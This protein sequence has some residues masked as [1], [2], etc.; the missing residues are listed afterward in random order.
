MK[1]VYLVC[2]ALFAAL[3]ITVIMRN[4]VSKAD[5]LFL[6]DNVEALTGFEG[7]FEYPRG[8][9]YITTCQVSVSSFMGI[10]VRCGNTI[11]VCQGGGSGCNSLSCP[12][13]PNSNN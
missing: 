2:L 3:M 7:E 1:K 8:Y 10:P 6:Q 11:I 4:E 5:S 9:P 12:M 13:H